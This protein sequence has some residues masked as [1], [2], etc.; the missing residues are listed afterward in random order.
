MQENVPLVFDKIIT[1]LLNLKIS[2]I[3]KSSNEV[4][5]HFY[6]LKIRIFVLRLRINS[7][8]RTN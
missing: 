8:N 5:L 6:D 1:C 3:I 4:T 2:V 7:A